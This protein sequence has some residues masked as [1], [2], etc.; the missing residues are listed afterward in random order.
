MR[1]SRTYGSVRGALSNERPYRDELL[2]RSEGPSWG[3]VTESARCRRRHHLAPRA[4][5]AV[6]ALR[7][8]ETVMPGEVGASRER[9][10][11]YGPTI[12]DALTALWEASDRV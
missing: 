9:R 10:R 4:K 2:N 3:G 6:R 11:R 7:R 1:E 8:R 12:K 5:H